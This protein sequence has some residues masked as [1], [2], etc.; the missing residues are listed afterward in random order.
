MKRY[1]KLIPAVAFAFCSLAA[2]AQSNGSSTN[3]TQ[4]QR[5]KSTTSQSGTNTKAGANTNAPS[6][7]YNQVQHNYLSNPGYNG[8]PLSSSGSQSAVDKSSKV[9]HNKKNPASSVSQ[10]RSSNSSNGNKSLSNNNT[11]TTNPDLNGSMSYQRQGNVQSGGLSAT[12]FYDKA[13]LDAMQSE[14]FLQLDRSRLLNEKMMLLNQKIELMSSVIN[15]DKKARDINSQLQTLDS[16]LED[17]DRQLN[18]GSSAE[19]N[20]S[21]GIHEDK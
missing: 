6:D 13:T 8:D 14:I 12:G 5:D 2:N 19:N 18:F 1:I 20:S 16:R 21:N 3:R 11:A 9:G 10:N 17:L 7:V 4:S 15:K